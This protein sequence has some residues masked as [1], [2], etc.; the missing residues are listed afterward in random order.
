[1][2][3]GLPKIYIAKYGI[4]KA[5][6]AAYRADQKAGRVRLDTVIKRAG[7]PKRRGGGMVKKVRRKRPG[8]T[9]PIA[10]ILGLGSGFFLAPEG[11][12]PPVNAILEGDAKAAGESLL[13]NFLF[14]DCVNK[15]FDFVNKGIGTKL[16]IVGLIVHWIAGKFGVNRALGRARVPVVRV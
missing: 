10:P 9:L 15:K 3:K 1:M 14:Y 7:K 8:F 6:W 4:S 5:A 11:W 16:T 2:P 13:A 12:N